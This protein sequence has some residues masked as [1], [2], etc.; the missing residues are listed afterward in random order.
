MK[1]VFFPFLHEKFVPEFIMGKVFLIDPGLDISNTNPSY[2]RPEKFPLDKISCEKYL[3]DFAIYTNY[4]KDPLEIQGNFFMK[5]LEQQEEVPS[6]IK[7]EIKKGENSKPLINYPLK[8]QLTFLLLW[9]LEEKLLE[10]TK[11]DEDFYKGLQKLR[12]ILGEN[13]LIEVDKSPSKSKLV[14]NIYQILPFE[15][16]LPYFFLVI[17][18]EKHMLVTTQ[19]DLFDMWMDFGIEFK[20]TNNEGFISSDYGYKYLFKK[21]SIPDME[22]LDKSYKVIFVGE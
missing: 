13:R 3:K 10:L 19:R 4:F 6:K 16:I 11:L 18:N 1:K 17:D 15:K 9:F 22:W 8:A 12:D 2:I 21:R 14:D 20:D 7:R 5:I